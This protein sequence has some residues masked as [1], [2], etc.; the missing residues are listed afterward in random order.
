[1]PA[2]LR[3]VAIAAILVTRF[4]ACPQFRLALS[5]NGIKGKGGEVLGQ[6]GKQA[7]FKSP[8]AATYILIFLNSVAFGLCLLG[9]S[10]VRIDPATLFHYGA[11]YQDALARK[12]YWRLAASAF[13]HANVLHFGL[14]MLC[15][16]A[17]SGLLEQRLGA[18]YF[19]IVYLA[20]AIGGAVA[21]IHGHPGPFLGV[22]ASGAISG[23]VGELY[24]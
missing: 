12:E 13:L 14:N 24:A 22:G 16:A 19:V 5:V 7:F 20:S 1:M 8:H 10:P 15:I 3:Y 23:I 17:W 6:R 9:N 21:S 2:K 11:L 18:T 4:A